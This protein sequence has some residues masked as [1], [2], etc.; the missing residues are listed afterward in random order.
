MLPSASRP[1]AFWHLCSQSRSIISHCDSGGHCLLP[2][3]NQ[4][5]NVTLHSRVSPANYNNPSLVCLRSVLTPCLPLSIT[6]TKLPVLCFQSSYT[7]SS[8]SLA[9]SSPRPPLPA[10]P[11]LSLSLP[12]LQGGERTLDPSQVRAEAV[13]GGPPPVGCAPGAAAATRR[14]GRWPEVCG[15]AAGTRHQGGG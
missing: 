8:Q 10:W 1:L 14:G 4:S 15:A 2:C 12:F 9:T 5:G 11:E 3:S 6:A 7:L 13:P